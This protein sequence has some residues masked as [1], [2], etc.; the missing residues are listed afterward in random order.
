MPEVGV[1]VTSSGESRSRRCS[2][3][4][5]PP[6]ASDGCGKGRGARGQR[7]V[8]RRHNRTG[9]PDCA[10]PSTRSSIYARTHPPTIQPAHGVPPGSNP[11]LPWLGGCGARAPEAA[12]SARSS[13]CCRRKCPGRRS[14]TGTR[15]A[16]SS[17]V[18]VTIARPA[19]TPDS[20][21]QTGLAL[22]SAGQ[23]R[24]PR[25]ILTWMTAFLPA[26]L[27]A[28]LQRPEGAQWARCALQVNPFAY[29]AS[30]DRSAP[31]IDQETYD[32]GWWPN[33]SATRSA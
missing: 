3:Q 6:D 13:E 15:L 7:V 30:N 25:S 21:G 10:R 31:A 19:G 17:S 23:F 16:L 18:S 20:R 14:A 27:T 12:A 22:P 24:V 32:R 4:A 33:W 2:G 5:L 28:A 26:P 11:G 8:R 9:P 1:G 29:F